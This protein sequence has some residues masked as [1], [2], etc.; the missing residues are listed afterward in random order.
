MHPKSYNRGMNK[1]CER[2]LVGLDMGGTHIDGVIIKD[3]KIFKTIKQVVDKDNLFMTIWT[4]L[5]ELLHGIDYSSI[6]RINLSTTIS[7]NAIVEDTTTLVGVLIS[8]G[9][10]VK[11]DFSSIKG[12]VHSI[13]GSID[14]R[15]IEVQ[16][17]QISEMYKSLEAF[18]RENISHAAIITKF[19]NRNPKHEI[20]IQKMIEPHMKRV[21]V[22]HKMSGVLNFPRRV[23]TSYLNA[24]V[25]EIFE[26]FATHIKESL[27][28]EG[29]DAPLY[30]LKADGGTMD[31]ESALLRP[32][33]TILSGPSA[34]FLG[35]M[36]LSHITQDALLLDIGGTTTDIFFFS[37]GE[38]LF[39]PLGA[40]ID[41]YKTLVR[42]IYSHSMG[43]GGDS[44]I[45]VKENRITI[46][47]VRKG[48]PYAYN[49]P[50]PTP[51]DAM[52]CL[53][54]IPDL[55]DEILNRA[56]EGISMIA[57]QLGKST[58]EISQLILDTMVKNIKTTTDSLLA[59]INSKPVYTIKKLLH[60][61]K[62]VP[63]SI[64]LI[65]G[66]SEALAP[67]IEKEYEIPAHVPQKYEVANAIGA[68]LARVTV[69]VTLLADTSIG[70]L[71]VPIRGVY[72]NID[73]HYTL[74]MAKKRVISLLKESVK[75]MGSVE[76]EI[77]YEIIEESSFNMV[78]G[79]MTKGKNIRVTG[80]VRPHLIY[81]IEEGK[82]I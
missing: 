48:P 10:G 69:D 77:E 39:E 51:T 56:Q 30:I 60:G 23:Y 33:E 38:I 2:V 27:K 65:G 26:T 62:V 61:K 52:I 6:E 44:V 57:T 74:D 68:A 71:S 28:T 81:T 64:H 50:N 25:M 66:P 46:G 40:T 4:T 13:S 3:Q 24:A 55:P 7:T 80:Q 54:L 42:A 75:K 18:K 36:A 21:T 41:G 5:K 1:R 82:E 16:E 73:T 59:K 8:S 58:K 47:P 45:E 43:C 79:F 76:K 19:S 20:A 22:G 37:D 31:I 72:E 29:I 17:L 9:P 63:T 78:E 11:H 53:N 34:S 70:K 12:V 35:C 67:R 14:H 49:G 32:V 15:G